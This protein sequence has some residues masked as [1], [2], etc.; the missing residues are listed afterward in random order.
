MR[1][2]DCVGSIVFRDGVCEWWRSY[3][4]YTEGGQVQGA[5]GCVCDYVITTVVLQSHHVML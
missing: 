4:P 5:C 2:Y 3:V 1:L